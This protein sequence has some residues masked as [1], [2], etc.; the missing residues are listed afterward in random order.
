MTCPYCKIELSA[1]VLRCPHCTSVIPQEI[2]EVYES[3]DLGR[4]AE[5]QKV[6]QIS[7]IAMP[8]LYI[9]LS[10]LILLDIFP[11]W[12]VWGILLI[13]LLMVYVFKGIIFKK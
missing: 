2:R 13:Y 3:I 7:V 4:R 9:F 6:L 8:I 10:F 5:D 11:A 1:I 12:L